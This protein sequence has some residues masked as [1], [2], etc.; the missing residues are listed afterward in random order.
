LNFGGQFGVQIMFIMLVFYDEL[1]GKVEC[2]FGQLVW[3]LRAWQGEC[4]LFSPKLT[5]LTLARISETQNL[6]WIRASRSGE[7]SLPKREI[8]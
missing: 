4:L 7:S 2:G 3:F 6:V 8:E 5:M 1:F